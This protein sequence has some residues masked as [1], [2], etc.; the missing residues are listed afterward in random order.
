MSH[1]TVKPG[2]LAGD[3]RSMASLA[4]HSPLIQSVRR[5]SAPG[6]FPVFSPGDGV[7]FH[8]AGGLVRARVSGVDVRAR[9]DLPLGTPYRL[10]VIAAPPHSGYTAGT[11]STIRA[12][13]L[14]LDPTAPRYAESLAEATTVADTTLL[15]APSPAVPQPGLQAFLVAFMREGGNFPLQGALIVQGESLQAAS[16][17]AMASLNAELEADVRERGELPEATVMLLNASEVPMAAAGVAVVASV[18]W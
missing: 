3:T 18:T 10:R 2:A 5:L 1:K 9:T 17:A 15:I 16:A 14:E 7:Q 13:C 12:A 11:D 4:F 6:T 8:V